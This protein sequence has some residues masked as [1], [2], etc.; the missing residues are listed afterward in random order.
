VMTCFFFIFSGSLLLL[1]LIMA[2]TKQ[3]QHNM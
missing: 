2:N 1:T 3:Q